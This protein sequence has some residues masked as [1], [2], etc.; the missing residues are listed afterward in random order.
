MNAKFLLKFWNNWH[1]NGG[2][3]SSGKCRLLSRNR[4]EKSGGGTDETLPFLASV[5]IHGFIND[6]DE[7]TIQNRHI[8]EVPRYRLH[9]TVGVLLNANKRL[10]TRHVK[11][12][13]DAEIAKEGHSWADT[14]SD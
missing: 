2:I 9:C 6:T 3:G 8:Q 12:V 1:R 13:I 4:C 11:G 14:T 7:F 10:W 5:S